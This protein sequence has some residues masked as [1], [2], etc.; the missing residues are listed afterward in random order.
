VASQT[1]QRRLTLSIA[2]LFDLLITPQEAHEGEPNGRMAN[3]RFDGKG[4]RGVSTSTLPAASRS[5]N[6]C[7]LPLKNLCSCRGI[8]PNYSSHLRRCHRHHHHHRHR[9]GISI[10]GSARHVLKNRLHWV[11][12]YKPFGIWYDLKIQFEM[13]RT[14]D[15]ISSA[16]SIQKRT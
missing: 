6:C 9:I 14:E 10:A 2:P 8:G 16:L 13:V 4:L 5:Y 7:K 12:K 1:A 11:T 15:K 3:F